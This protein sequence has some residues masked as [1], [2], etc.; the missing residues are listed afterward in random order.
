MTG[1]LRI[2]PQEP[3]RSEG[4]LTLSGI[5]EGPGQERRELWYRLPE[6]YESFIS[7]SADFLVA[8]CIYPVMQAGQDV[9]VHGQVAPSLLH[10][11]VE[12]QLAWASWQSGLSA[13]DISAD[14]EAESGD[15]GDK[16]G[17]LVAFSGGVD[18]CFSAFRHARAWETRFPSRVAAGLM[19]HG[20]DIPL[21]EP[22]AFDSSFVR[23]TRMLASLGLES[24]PMATNYRALVADWTHSY[25]AAIASCLMLL[26]GAYGEG[27]IGQGLAYE[28][29]R[30][31]NE[32]SNPLTDALLSSA[33]FTIVPDGGGYLRADKIRAMSTWTE[34][35]G[36][37]RVC[38]AGAQRDRNCCK[39]EKCIRNI[40]TFRVLG[41]GRPPCFEHDVSIEQ[42]RGLTKLKEITML[43]Q[44]DNIV[45]LAHEAGPPV[46]WAIALERRLARNRKRQASAI[47]RHVSRLP[48]YARRLAARL[49]LRSKPG[50][51][52]SGMR[53]G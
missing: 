39:C 9:R 4:R 25:G 40:L 48:Y 13:V 8:G 33:A 3:T 21:E 52:A 26:A 16:R 43:T 14:R 2:W 1:T 53:N 29:F 50:A 10:N 24:I 51:G 11:L 44:Y 32:G 23:S 36:N 27:M 7:T 17:A 28:H 6:Q 45:K 37:L 5:L 19:V 49:R 38:W 22:E 41:L 34:F 35:L 20:F 46:P 30:H 42:I 18:S 31:L 15:K 12:F 47:A